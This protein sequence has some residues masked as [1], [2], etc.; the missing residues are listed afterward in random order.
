MANR[1]RMTECKVQR[2]SIWVTMSISE[3]LATQESDCQCIECQMPVRPHRQAVNGMAAHFEH[4]QRNPNCSRSDRGRRLVPSQGRASDNGHGEVPQ[5]QRAMD[6]VTRGD[7]AT[8]KDRV[9]T[10]VDFLDKEKKPVRENIRH[11][12]NRLSRPGGTV[13]RKIAALMV[14]I[15]EFRNSAEHDPGN[16]T[17]TPTE[18]NVL[19]GAS[20]AIEEWMQTR[21]Y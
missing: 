12:I 17:P 9:E 15:T 2:G 10:I 21:K 14:T 6:C 1:P 18:S 19:R 7:L 8:L 20:Q 13:P 11:R 16:P 5:P 3:A 4:I